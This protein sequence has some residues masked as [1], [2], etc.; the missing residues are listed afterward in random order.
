M[1]QTGPHWAEALWYAVEE[2]VQN[3]ATPA[4]F[5]E[6]VAECWEQALRDRLRDEP[7]VFREP[8]RVSVIIRGAPRV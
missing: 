6:E 8:A 5:R 4:A 2:A 1:F 7:K 3:G